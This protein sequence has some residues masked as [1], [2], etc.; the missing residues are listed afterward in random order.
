MRVRILMALSV[1]VLLSVGVATAAAGPKH[2]GSQQL[3]QNAGGTFSTKTNSSFYAPLAKNERVL[4]T[5]NSYSDSSAAQAMV[6][7]CYGD[8]GQ[9]A[10]SDAPGFVTCWKN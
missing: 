3:C 9:S 10:R 4:W 7:S 2:P 5:C 1:V 8:S 6:S